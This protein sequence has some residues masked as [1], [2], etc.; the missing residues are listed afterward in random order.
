MSQEDIKE[1]S[2]IIK[3]DT[4]GTTE[5]VRSAIERLST[6]KVKV[7][8]ISC[9]VSDVND[10]DVML[11]AASGAIIIGFHVRPSAQARDLAEQ[12]KVDIRTY[13]IVF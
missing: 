1:L 7:S 6:N 11:A 3:A 8:I 9:S 10:N 5:A 13:K 4:Q 12:E 2:M